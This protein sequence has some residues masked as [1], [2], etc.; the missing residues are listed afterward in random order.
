MVTIAPRYKMHLLRGKQT[1]HRLGSA[2]FA[3]A[4]VAFAACLVYALVLF[5]FVAATVIMHAFG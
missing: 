1:M 5:L 3:T 4:Y 2:F